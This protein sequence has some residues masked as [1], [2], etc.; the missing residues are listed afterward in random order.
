MAKDNSITKYIRQELWIEKV[1]TTIDTWQNIQ[2]I[3]V[4][5]DVRDAI[6]KFMANKIKRGIDKGTLIRTFM[7]IA[8]TSLL[9]IKM[10]GIK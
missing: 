9:Y 8:V 2:G 10:K 1:E 5:Q 6:V 3:S 7:Q 4:P